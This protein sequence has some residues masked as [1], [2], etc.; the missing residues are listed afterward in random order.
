[1]IKFEVYA[2][3]DHSLHAIPITLREKVGLF[4]D[5]KIIVLPSL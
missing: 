3:A 1:V 2:T 5:L 4:C